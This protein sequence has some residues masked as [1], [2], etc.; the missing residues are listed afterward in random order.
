MAAVSDE[1]TEETPEDRAFR[2][3]A[4]AW[5]AD[6]APAAATS[7][8]AHAWQRM[9]AD[10]RFAAITWPAEYGGRDGTPRQQAIFFE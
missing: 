6:H 10:A 5:L 7:G 9:L 2:A 1:V 4:Q 8:D 3:E